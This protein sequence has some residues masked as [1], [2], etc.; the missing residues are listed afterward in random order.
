MA[1]DRR[2][3]P[4]D[5][6][7]LIALAT[8]LVAVREIAV[9]ASADRL[10]PAA[11]P[12]EDPGALAPRCAV[13]QAQVA[14]R[15]C[16]FAAI[17]GLPP[18][19]RRLTEWLSGPSLADAPDGDL[20]CVLAAW[21]DVTE[22]SL[23]DW[24]SDTRVLAGERPAAT[25]LCPLLSQVKGTEEARAP[26]SIV[27]DLRLP[28]A[29][30]SGEGVLPRVA[31]AD[32]PGGGCYRALWTEL[33]RGAAALPHAPRV[34][35][36]WLDSF[37]SLLSVA[38][39]A[40]PADPFEPCPVDSLIDVVRLAA[41]CAVS[42]SVHGRHASRKPRKDAYRLVVGEFS[43]IQDF[44]LGTDP[45][46]PWQP[47]IVAGGRSAFVKLASE[48][49]ALAVLEQLGMPSV[50][51]VFTGGSK[52]ML[53][54][55]NAETFDGDL[56]QLRERFD[57]WSLQELAGAGG[58]ALGWS[59]AAATAVSIRRRPKYSGD[60]RYFGH[61]YAMA[62]QSLE[63]S[64][65]RRFRL[66]EGANPVIHGA[67][68]AFRDGAQP[69]SLDGVSPACPAR[70]WLA[71]ALLPARQLAPVSRASAFQ[72][73]L[74]LQ[75]GEVQQVVARRMLEVRGEPPQQPQEGGFAFFGWSVTVETSEIPS[76]RTPPDGVRIWD[77]GFATR[78]DQRFR[79]LPVRLIAHHA[80]QARPGALS[81]LKGD[82]DRLGLV[83]R[84]GIPGFS[85][86][87]LML[88]A[89]QLDHFFSLHVPRLLRQR[90]PR[91]QTVLA[92]GD[93]F[94][95]IGPAEDVLALADSL[96][97][98]WQQYTR[99]PSLTFSIG[100]E[101][102]AQRVALQETDRR[103]EE[104]LVL[105][106]RERNSVAVH[107]R[108]L[109]WARWRMLRGLQARLDG[110]LQAAVHGG[111]DDARPALLRAL[112]GIAAGLG[113]GRGFSGLRWRSLVHQAVG[114]FC[115]AVLGE[116]SSARTRA[117]FQDLLWTVERDGFALLGADMR[118]PLMNLMLGA[119]KAGAAREGSGPAPIESM[120]L[121]PL[122]GLL[123][124]LDWS[125]PDE[126]LF[127]E[128]AQQLA[129]HLQ[130]RRRVLDDLLQEVRAWDLSCDQ[131]EAHFPALRPQMAVSAHRQRGDSQS[132]TGAEVRRA[133]LERI[134]SAEH[135]HCA[136]WFL[137]TVRIFREI[138]HNMGLVVPR[139]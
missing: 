75:L 12:A 81:V 98:H 45:Q 27:T 26:G 79:G 95:F 53:L 29:P 119:S 137:E 8:L 68:R 132:G 134:G 92:G 62:L 4:A 107:G 102:G 59:Y 86:A 120:E 55:P 111:G 93:D 87:R 76:L 30:V 105:A 51:Q 2:K 66:L 11:D 115:A 23:A 33:L 49:A 21:Q 32:S 128:L 91:V 13:L 110:Q 52:F 85:L 44:I 126:A 43:P 39:N 14:E 114:K 135:L 67:L 9:R 90:H 113:D 80:G 56:E 82:V 65:M 71:M 38:L 129:V 25:G 46:G 138:R 77:A 28:L 47:G 35:R 89:R 121:P 36:G 40:V 123:A 84:Q 83:F 136:R 127:G 70:P 63:G 48:L 108:A 22:K 10:P 125:S 64:R 103:A 96:Q 139:A 1:Q 42:Q 78:E 88:A 106:K 72:L 15:L 101:V 100:I 73:A 104:A 69:C 116:R 74:A 124:R 5:S 18:Q 130:R 94:T 118:V 31:A 41:A 99:N 97:Q 112:H 34:Q 20:A 6:T 16:E 50:C 57:T 122:D 60:W 109:P 54:V 131:R 19:V 61:A 37:D 17:E 117:L 24:T 3:P 58:I 133:V 7:C